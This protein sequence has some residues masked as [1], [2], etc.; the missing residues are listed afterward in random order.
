MDNHGSQ[1]IS[2]EEAGAI[3]AQWFERNP[4]DLDDLARRLDIPPDQ[5]ES[6]RRQARGRMSMEKWLSSQ[7]TTVAPKRGLQFRPYMAIVGAQLIV[8][9]VFGVLKSRAS[10]EEGRVRGAMQDFDQIQFIDN[11]GKR[12]RT[13]VEQVTSSPPTVMRFDPGQAN[14]P[15]ETVLGRSLGAQIADNTITPSVPGHPSFHSP[16]TYQEPPRVG[17]GRL[18]MPHPGM[19]GMRAA[20]RVNVI[21]VTSD[22]GRINVNL[23]PDF[24]IILRT[25]NA[26][27]LA[28][29]DT[30]RNVRNA[31]LL[32]SGVIS[33]SVQAFIKM[34][35]KYELI[36]TKPDSPSEASW[37][38][39]S[40]ELGNI[41]SHQPIHWVKS[42]RGNLSEQFVKVNDPMQ[43]TFIEPFVKR[44][45][46][47]GPEVFSTVPIADRPRA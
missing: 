46:K 1:K 32:T 22:L 39:L 28:N 29:G 18:Q 23:P 11:T 41:N 2:S 19:G 24:R 40:I 3:V 16:S 38:M 17:G 9:L 5:L 47:A 37:A 44:I 25:P 31:K 34:V 42:E 36:P 45:L 10:I 30:T 21:N 26:I 15:G 14:D 6:L 35:L 43:R 8:G 4:L 13:A 27:Y 12:P 7:K 33:P 20:P